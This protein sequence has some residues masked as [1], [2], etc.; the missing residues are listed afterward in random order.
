MQKQF[1]G[2]TP[3]DLSKQLRLNQEVQKVD[4]SDPDRVVVTC[5]DGSE[6]VAEQ[7]LTTVSVGVLKSSPGLFVPPLPEWKTKAIEV[8]PRKQRV[9]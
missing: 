3:I 5:T 6:Y 4:W 1:P 9:S 8:S 7:V 2:E